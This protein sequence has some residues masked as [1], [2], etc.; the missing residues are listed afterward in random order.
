MKTFYH[1]AISVPVDGCFTLPWKFSTSAAPPH[2][3]LKLEDGLESMFESKGE[4]YA[5]GVGSGSPLSFMMAARKIGVWKAYVELRQSERSETL[6]RHSFEIDVTPRDY[7]DST[8]T[9]G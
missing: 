9:L 5:P 8:R 6:Y 7:S 3:Y 4:P 2:W 1:P